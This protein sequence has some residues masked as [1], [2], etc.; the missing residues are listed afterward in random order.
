MIHCVWRHGYWTL[1]ADGMV[2]FEHLAVS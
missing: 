2:T 1:M